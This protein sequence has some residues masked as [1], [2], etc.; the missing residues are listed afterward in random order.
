MGI[1]WEDHYLAS[2][3]TEPK[4]NEKTSTANLAGICDTLSGPLLWSL[5]QE[6]NFCA[7]DNVSLDPRDV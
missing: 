1:V 3:R 4:G 2:E 5:I 6:N 7:V